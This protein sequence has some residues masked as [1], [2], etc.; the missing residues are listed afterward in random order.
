MRRQKITMPPDTIT[1]RIDGWVGTAD[2]M[3]VSVEELIS[4][5]A[6]AHNPV[7]A[8][9]RARMQARHEEFFGHD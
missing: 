3:P 6:G 9:I 4:R 2:R 5:H 1:T 7:V 8:A